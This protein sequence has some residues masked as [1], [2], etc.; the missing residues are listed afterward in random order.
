M[1][2]ILI[3]VNVPMDIVETTVKLVC[4]EIHGQTWNYTNDVIIQ[5]IFQLHL[6]HCL[7]FLDD[8]D[9]ESNPCENDGKCVDGVASYTCECVEGFTGFNCEIS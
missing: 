8:D 2:S 4:S 7:K 1:E 5:I 3:L 9:C 6:S